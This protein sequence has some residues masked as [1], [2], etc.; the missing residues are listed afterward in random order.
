MTTSSGA[1]SATGTGRSTGPGLSAGSEVEA[2]AWSAAE[3]RA[4]RSVAVAAGALLEAGMSGA[5]VGFAERLLAGVH[6]AR[7]RGLHRLAA[8]ATRVVTGVGAAERDDD[9]FS[10]RSLSADLF[11]T[12]SVAHAVTSG[13]GS[14]T[15]WRGTA[16]TVYQQV[17]ALRLAGLCLEPVVSSAGYA[18]VVVWLIDADGGLWSV[19]DVRPGPPERA[20]ISADA[21]V[22]V[23][24]SGLTH[25]KLSRA[26]LVMAAAT[27]NSEG[28]LGTGARVRAAAAGPVAW[29]DPRVAPRFGQ[30]DGHLEV[31]GRL[32]TAQARSPRLLALTVC[33]SLGEAL[34]AVDAAGG[35]VRLVAAPG[36]PH[37]LRR[38]NL[39]VL[40]EHPGLRF[41]AVARPGGEGATD[42][43]ADRFLGRPPTLE[44]IAVGGGDLHLPAA[45]GAHVDLGFDRLER[46]LLR[47]TGPSDLPFPTGSGVGDP[48]AAYSRRLDRVVSGGRTTLNATGVR[49]EVHGEAAQL[50]RLGLVAPAGLLERLVVAA[51]APVPDEFGRIEGAGTHGPDRLAVAWLAAATCRRALFDAPAGA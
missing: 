30:V 10:L 33:G 40:A 26:G 24:S 11:E 29:T 31:T 42:I 23:G 43:A 13:T 19:A 14:P 45:A 35:G 51:S 38:D 41:L 20:L 21:T 16:R 6:Q 27:A 17:G 4:A 1:D 25:R 9:S 46:R 5:D 44:L 47:P 48:L 49:A 3:Q 8:A 32:P 15:D 50:R 34:L 22:A 18:G 7:L 12:L 39:G 2:S 28:R 37:R 36:D